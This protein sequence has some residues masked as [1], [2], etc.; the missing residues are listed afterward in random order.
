MVE[1]QRS[2]HFATSNIRRGSICKD[3]RDHD[4]AEQQNGVLP[5]DGV[6]LGRSDGQLVIREEQEVYASGSF[7]KRM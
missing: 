4:G 1:G 3:G 5:D 6:S 2:C 7:D